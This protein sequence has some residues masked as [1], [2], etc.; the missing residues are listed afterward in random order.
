MVPENKAMYLKQME[1][2]KE[3]R[4]LRLQK[5]IWDEQNK[6]RDDHLLTADACYALFDL[7]HFDKA[8]LVYT[9]D[10]RSIEFIERPDVRERAKEL[11][12]SPK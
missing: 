11:I 5:A 12:R 4:H 3:L 6:D 8:R 10:P 2:M 9:F 1:Q 7:A